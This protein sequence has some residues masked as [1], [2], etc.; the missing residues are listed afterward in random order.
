MRMLKHNYPYEPSAPLYETIRDLCTDS[1][2][3]FADN[4]AFTYKVKG[5]D[6][7]VVTVDY[8]TFDR[9]VRAVGTRAIQDGCVG[10]HCALIGK[11]SYEWIVTYFALLSIGAVLAPLDKEWTT[12][13][14]IDT[15]KRAEGVRLFCDADMKDKALAICE[16]NGIEN[17]V[18]FGG[19]WTRTFATYKAEGEALLDSGDNGFET[20]PLDPDKL[21]MLVFTSGT[22]GK[23]KGVMHCQRALTSNV[24]GAYAVLHVGTRT[25][26]LLPPHHT[27]GSTISILSTVIGGA[28]MYISSGI[29]YVLKELQYQKP[30]YLLLVPLY[31][32][33]FY[34]RI[35]AAAKDS[36]KEKLLKRMIKISNALRKVGIDLRKAFFKKAVLSAFGGELVFCVSG[37]APIS[38]E[39]IDGFDAFGVQIINGY[40]ITECA[41]LV[42][43]NRMRFVTPGSVGVPIPFE[44]VKVVNPSEDGEGEICIKGPNV[45]LGYYGDPAATAEA[46]DEDGFY[47]T[48]DLGHIDSEQRIFITGRL[49]NLIILSNGKNV[50]PEEIESAIYDATPGIKDLVVYEGISARG[51]E[52][53]AIVL[54]VLPDEDW[55]KKEGV[56]DFEAYI[57]PFVDNYNR[58]AVPYKKIG[59]IRVRTEEFPKNT[60]RKIMRFKL[61]RSID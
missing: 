3:K 23:G 26:G 30:D 24:Y 39:I 20:V 25:V 44:E 33:T 48:G 60:L 19:D 2:R 36:G 51:V 27:F 56:E 58:T 31:L 59:M 54:E 17:P 41:P 7:D 15:V 32:E 12:E 42:S 11:L 4:I 47:H 61:D 46:I 35:W 13:D 16:A 43:A 53:N 55:M 5:S 10:A 37:G 38:Q 34:R 8:K 6:K 57:K 49:K 45:M 29:R 9:D 18:A 14:L 40:G 28:N 52:Y 1:C 21:A 50:Y 22:T